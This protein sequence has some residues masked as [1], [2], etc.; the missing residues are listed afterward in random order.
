MIKIYSKYNPPPHPG[1]S[2]DEPTLTQQHFQKECDVNEMLRKFGATG[3]LPT[4]EGAFYADATQISDYQSALETVLNID[5]QF[6]QL[7]STCRDRFGNSP[8]AFLDF[9]HQPGADQHFADLG[10][11]VVPVTSLDVTGTTDTNSTTMENIE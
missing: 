7:P 1:E 5:N 11:T 8:E 2:N 6:A 10:L 9:I 3:E 4:K